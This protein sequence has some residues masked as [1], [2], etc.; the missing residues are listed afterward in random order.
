[1]RSSDLYTYWYPFSDFD[2]VKYIDREIPDKSVIDNIR[3][4]PDGLRIF[5]DRNGKIIFVD[6]VVLLHK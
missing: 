2:G 5:T 6:K 3:E 1:M 4:Y